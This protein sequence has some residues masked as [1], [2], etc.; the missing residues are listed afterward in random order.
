VD[1]DVL[2]HEAQKKL[3]GDEEAVPKKKKA[4][5]KQQQRNAVGSSR[6]AVGSSTGVQAL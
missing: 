1:C 6:S 5:S 2:R 4:V 3:K